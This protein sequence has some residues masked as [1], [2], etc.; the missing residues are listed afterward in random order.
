MLGAFRGMPARLAIVVLLATAC[1]QDPQFI[2]KE[3]SPESAGAADGTVAICSTSAA[4][5][6]SSLVSSECQVGNAQLAIEP[7]AVDL[8]MGDTESL[9]AFLVFADGRKVDVTGQAR[10]SS[11][12]PR[13][14]A[15]QS[16]G[17]VVALAAGQTQVH[18][19]Y[20]DLNGLSEARISDR[21]FVKNPEVELR[22]HGFRD[23][24]LLPSGLDASV[25]WESSDVK[26]CRLLVDGKDFS[27]Q[28]KGSLAIKV[29]F[30]GKIEVLC[31]T[32]S[33]E[34]ISD[35]VVIRLTTP[36]VQLAVD[37]ASDELII[38][39]PKSVQLKWLSSNADF[40]EVLQSGTRVTTGLVGESYAAVNSS[41]KFEVICRDLAGNSASS[42]VDVSLQYQTK[43]SFAP[44]YFDQIAGSKTQRPVSIMFALDVTGS[45]SSQIE[46]V[47]SGVQDF[48]TQLSSKGFTPKIGVIPFRD[49]VPE[50]RLLGDV[51]EGRLELTDNVEEVKR[52]VGT[53][54][55]TGGGDANE[56]SLGAIRSA[57]TA[58]RTGDLRP[59]A[60]K[61]IMLVTD[62]PGHSGASTTDCSLEGLVNQFT[63]LSIEEQQNFKLFYS[64]PSTGFGCGGFSSGLR[65]MSTLMSRV[66]LTEPVL[67]KRGGLIAWPFANKN[68][69]NDVVA[70]LEK[71]NPP[72][73]LACLNTSATVSIDGVVQFVEELKDYAGA[74]RQLESGGQQL[75]A[76]TLNA[77]QFDGL[78][79]GRGA[80][81]VQRCCFSKAA[82]KSGVF[83]ACLVTPVAE[84][85]PFALD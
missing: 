71:V 59:D 12:Q 74:Y 43:L 1:S 10:W 41:R 7:S 64:T 16:N 82:A 45:M 58:L 78:S 40:C 8:K 9:K 42:A 39:G 36:K 84:A 35:E 55:A 56:A 4:S 61:I 46:T 65:Q 48:V 51:P 2:D 23:L 17:G 5:G 19:V 80:L 67:E 85:V 27:K 28:L 72:I 25:T 44:G 21:D 3:M 76:K 31:E 33:G 26:S 50:S 52:F 63:V 20:F 60:V 66:L 29:A 69:V 77:E 38:S 15:V 34:Q 37:G 14:L 6:V 79:E 83:D 68:L 18:A 54:K 32:E 49:K 13:L 22:V 73:D 11:S 70:M 47:K 24:A 53:L 75:I 62:Q 57:L 30:D 81:T